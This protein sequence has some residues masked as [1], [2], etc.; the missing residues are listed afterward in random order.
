MIR[1]LK[2][3]FGMLALGFPLFASASA[4]NGN[5]TTKT[6]IIPANKSYVEPYR[7]D[8]PVRYNQDRPS[9]EIRNWTESGTNISWYLYA[10]PAVYKVYL[11]GKLP[12][13]DKSDLLLNITRTD[14]SFRPQQAKLHF[15]SDSNQVY[16]ATL[17]ISDAGY[18]RF[19]LQPK[20][21]T[22]KEFL[23]VSQLKFVAVSGDSAEVHQTKYLSSPSVHLR[24]GPE[25]QVKREYDWL[26]GEITVPEGYDPMYT[27][28][29]S[30]GFYR[31]YFG[32]QANRSTERRVLFSVWDS[33]NEGVD[34]NKVGQTDR[35]TLLEKGKDVTGGGFGNEGTGGQTYRK[36]MWKTGDKVQFIMNM[37]KLPDN[38]VVYSAWFKDNE[39]DG[40]Q[41]MASWK[42]PRE[43]RYFDGYYSFL[44]NFG[45]GNGQQ[46]RKALYGNA[47]GKIAGGD[48]VSF[49]RARM[50]YTDGA[51]GQRCDYAGGQDAK[52]KDLF[53]MSSGGYSATQYNQFTTVPKGNKIPVTD[54]KQLE[55]QVDHAINNAK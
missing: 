30:L 3:H 23:Q 29:M 6:F 36:Y 2:R 46:T 26:Y 1:H 34:R 37:R 16:A 21:K 32:I 44:E 28:Y 45:P 48:W 51:P 50:T 54:L 13:G 18:Y 27:Y 40:W 8:N 24:F 41:Y 52:Q 7:E 15:E 22:G 38:Y 25:D 49:N 31:G 19:E 9:A 39:K 33:S 10:K 14:G 12:A 5:D 43:T 20:R 11:Q 53:Y 47:W 55:A 4:Y 17:N 35:V 42:A